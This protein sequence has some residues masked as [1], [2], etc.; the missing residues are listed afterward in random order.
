M[1]PHVK[2]CGI[3]NLEDALF[4]AHA[5]A[6]SLGF[7]FYKKSPRFIEPAEAAKIIEE[8]PAYITP[9]GV[10]VNEHRS[11]IEHAVRDSGIR[12]I[13]LS[14]NEFPDQCQGYAVKIWKAFRI[15]DSEAV[16]S[17]KPY[18]IDAAMLDGAGDDTYGC[19]GKL[20]DFSIAVG[21][22]EYH[23]LMLAGGL[24]PDNIIGAIQAVEPFG[25]DVCSGVEASP[26]KKD[27]TQVTL[28]FERLQRLRNQ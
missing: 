28:L 19:S 12:V 15:R 4:C 21:M 9:V 11:A 23:P 24:N 27:H 16:E 20:P 18:A 8:L 3:T 22:K 6:D 2:I 25:V 13:Q 10:F 5:G 14:G 26:G 17:V 7:I 1:K